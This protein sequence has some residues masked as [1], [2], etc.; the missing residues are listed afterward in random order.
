MRFKIIPPVEGGYQWWNIIDTKSH[1]YW[2][3]DNFAVA[4]VSVRAPNAEQAAIIL[5]ER[6]NSGDNLS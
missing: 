3:E 1:E 2:G 5:L 6:F 4:T